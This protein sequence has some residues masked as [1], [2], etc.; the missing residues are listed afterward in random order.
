MDSEISQ[1]A[2]DLM[3]AQARLAL[4]ACMA[5]QNLAEQPSEEEFSEIMRTILAACTNRQEH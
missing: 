4:I 1:L 5:R 3:K 2:N